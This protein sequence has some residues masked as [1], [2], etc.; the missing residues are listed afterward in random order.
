MLESG[1][2]GGSE[3]N[4]KHYL[5]EAYFF[6]AYFYANKLDSLGDFPIIKQIIPDNYEAVKLNSKRRPR[7]EVA[8]FII[9]DLDSAYYFMSPTPPVSNRLTRDCAALLKSRVAL[10]EGTWEKYHKGTARVPGGPGWPGAQ[11]DYLKNFSINIDNEIRYFLEEAKK[12]AQ[13]VADNYTLYNDYPALFN[14]NSLDG[15]PEVL[16][17]RA[18]NAGITPAVNHFVV[19]Y[20]Q[21]NGGG[22]SG[23]TRSMID[24]Y[25]MKNG[26][27]IYASGSEYKGDRTYQDVADGRDLAWHSIPCCREIC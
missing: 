9:Q 20:L 1:E 25:L 3:A 21:R 8:R 4:N 13:L 10:F 5:G 26:L 18:Y 14:S 19:G 22:N 2:L 6:R 24:T 27:P 15:I 16:L 12:A 17:W 7:N 23:Y 11:K